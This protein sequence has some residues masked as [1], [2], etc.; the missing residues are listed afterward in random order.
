MF[1]TCILVCWLV[2]VSEA[3]LDDRAPIAPEGKTSAVVRDVVPV[4]SHRTGIN[5]DFSNFN[6]WD[7]EFDASNEQPSFDLA[8]LAGMSA[9]TEI[10]VVGLGWNLNLEVQGFSWF[11]EA[12]IKIGD[13]LSNPLLFLQ[14][15][16]G[17][18]FGSP[19]PM[20][21]NSGGIVSLGD[22][23]LP[24]LVL[25]D[26]VVEL[27]LYELLD[28]LPDAIDATY[29]AGSVLTFDLLMTGVS[30]DFNGDGD[31]SCLDVD[32]LVGEIV[33]GTNSPTYDVTGDGLVDQLDLSAW[34]VEAGAA[35][36]PSMNPYL[37]ADMD[38]DGVVD[39]EDFIV[40]NE[41]RFTEIAAFCSGDVTADGVVDGNDF[42]RWNDYRFMSSGDV[43]AVP[44]PACGLAWLVMFLLAAGR[45][46]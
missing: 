10:T 22:S 31:Y 4:I 24:D 19:T 43:A 12:V 34:L 37:P 27:E 36:L 5:V 25:T 33:A 6:S 40:W 14:P 42:I 1:G 29:L 3:A 38:L 28:D 2:A 8:S 46:R 39:A 26:G 7:D 16:Q 32:A 35:E 11:S 44:E 20:N 15:G 17:D 13:D 9:G 30:G 23:G 21:Y 41:N 18:D 45:R